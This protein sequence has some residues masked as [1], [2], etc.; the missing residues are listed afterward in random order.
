M[1]ELIRGSY[2]Y[3]L[4]YTSFVGTLTID[5]VNDSQLLSI[6]RP[7]IGQVA[8]VPPAQQAIAIKQAR[9]SSCCVSSSRKAEKVNRVAIGIGFHEV[10]IGIEHVVAKSGSKGEPKKQRQLLTGFCSCRRCTHRAH[11]WMVVSY[12]MVIDDQ[13]RVKP[14]HV[15]VA[16]AEVIASTVTADHDIL[17][18]LL[19][20]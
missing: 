17:G 13:S 14:D 11:A 10:A 2:T 3:L 9:E 5:A 12:L 16:L 20:I 4:P 18:C 7:G 6:T 15:R 8:L 1:F 19:G